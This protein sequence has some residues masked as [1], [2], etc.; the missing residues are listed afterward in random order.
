MQ[1][2]KY[3]FDD[4]IAAIATALTPAALGIIRTSGKNCI[5]LVSNIFSNK[6]ALLKAEPNSILYGWIIDPKTQKKIDEVTLAIYKS[7][8]SFTGEDSVEFICHGGIAVI[9]RIYRLLIGNGF[10]R[11]EGGEFTFRSFINGKTDLTKVEAIREII[12]SKTET[13][14]EFAAER[15]SGELF[16]AI[17]TIKEKLLKVIAA[18]DVQIEYPEDEETV[19]GVFSHNLIKEIY[20]E[21]QRLY[22]SWASEKIFIQGAKVVL[23]GKTNAGKSSLFN[24]LLKEDR[25]IV[26]DI[27]GTTRD[28]LEA[29]LNFNGIPVSL[30]DTAGIR[31]TNDEIEAIGVKRSLQI[32]READL[33]LYLLDSAKIIQNKKLFD[34]DIKF[35]NDSAVP[36]ITVFTKTDLLNQ[37][38]NQTLSAIVKKEE[39]KN[40]ILISS[41]TTEGIKALSETAYNILVSER[42]GSKQISL[43]SERQK[44]AVGKSLEFIKTAEQNAEQGFPLDMVTEDL[45]EAVRFLGEITGEVNSEDILDKV[46]SG[47]CVGK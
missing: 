9:L 23:A 41:K 2:S 3:S 46:F 38:E 26:S 31:Y 24:T 42:K 43:G 33:I 19:N 28:W 30:Y 40:F 5:E 32:S 1:T 15:L 44:E 4:P 45:E 6:K 36:L 14:A 25:A 47:F 21:L 16:S 29:S 20:S 37:D 7:P 10:R 35:I 12:E 11:A 13:A 34:D 17:K 27:H 39:I 22:E 8:K 18:I